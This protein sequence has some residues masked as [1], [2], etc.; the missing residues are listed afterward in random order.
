MPPCWQGLEAH[1]FV[2]TQDLPSPVKPRKHSHV[3][4]FVPVTVQSETGCAA[5]EAEERPARVHRFGRMS[6]PFPLG[7]AHSSLLKCSYRSDRV[8]R[9]WPVAFKSARRTDRDAK[10][11]GRATLPIAVE[12]FSAACER[13]AAKA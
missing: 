10:G 7:M 8:T 13:R 11:A 9:D 4:V 6:G 5:D 1:S 12:R 2:S 3:C